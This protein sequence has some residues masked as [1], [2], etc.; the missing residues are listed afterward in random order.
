MVF[1]PQ[2]VKVPSYVGKGRCQ[3]R[4]HRRRMRPRAGYQSFDEYVA[5]IP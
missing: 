4:R 1:E 3:E 2:V 5:A